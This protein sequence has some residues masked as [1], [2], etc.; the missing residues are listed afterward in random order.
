MS[1]LAPETVETLTVIRIVTDSKEVETVL[2]FVDKR[3]HQSF[4]TSPPAPDILFAAFREEEIVGTIALDVSKDG[5]L[6][7]EHHYTWDPVG[8]SSYKACTS[9]Q[10]GRWIAIVP[11]ISAALAYVAT[12][13]AREIG[14]TLGVCEAKPAAAARMRMLGIVLYPVEADVVEANIRFEDRPYYCTKPYPCVYL[15]ELS[16]VEEAL[17]QAVLPAC[18]SGRVFPR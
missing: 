15:M 3:F 12:R 7:F 10:Y 18:I 11:R 8:N 13:Y 14:K 9:V 4:G 16:Q 2:R 5:L 1:A 6:P 17:E